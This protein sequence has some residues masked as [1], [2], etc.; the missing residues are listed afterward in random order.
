MK[1]FD[2]WWEAHKQIY[3]YR[4]M[5]RHNLM[6]GWKVALEWLMSEIGDEEYFRE[7]IVTFKI[8]KEL[9]DK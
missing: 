2:K 4:V 7:S 6:V 9:E 3:P 8:K 5:Y 1:E